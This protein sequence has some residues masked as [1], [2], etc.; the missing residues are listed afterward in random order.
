MNVEALLKYDDIWRDREVLVGTKVPDYSVLVKRW[1]LLQRIIFT[2]YKHIHRV[3]AQVLALKVTNGELEKIIGK[4]NKFTDCVD[5]GAIRLEIGKSD[6]E[7][8]LWPV[9]VRA[10][11]GHTK[12]TGGVVTN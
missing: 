4:R 10:T 2:E 7:I 5:R 1:D 6:R 11:M 3:R 12:N 8:W 9:A